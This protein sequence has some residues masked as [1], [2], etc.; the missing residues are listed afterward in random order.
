MQPK[1]TAGRIV[2][3]GDQPGHSYA[4]IIIEDTDEFGIAMLTVFTPNGPK[5]EFGV[6]YYDSQE[7]ETALRHWSWPLI[8]FYSSHSYALPS[9]EVEE[10][11]AEEPAAPPTSKATKS[12]KKKSSKKSK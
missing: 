6:P 8:V 9:V 4:A 3:Y 10:A 2:R 12:S 11:P 7:G 5:Q 1:A